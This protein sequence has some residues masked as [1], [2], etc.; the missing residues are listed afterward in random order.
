MIKSV[1]DYVHPNKSTLGILRE[2][3]VPMV[4]TMLQ[5]P[6][7]ILLP[8][9]KS[10]PYLCAKSMPRL[11]ACICYLQ[12][13]P[14]W[15]CY[16]LIFFMNLIFVGLGPRRYWLYVQ[17]MCQNACALRGLSTT[18]LFVMVYKRNCCYTRSVLKPREQYIGYTTLTCRQIQATPKSF[19]DQIGLHVVAGNVHLSVSRIVTGTAKLIAFSYNMYFCDTS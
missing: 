12:V 7:P 2:P 3:C 18:V 5:Q 19:H 15:F 14:V 4:S 16:K 13:A 9:Q 11:C 17:W 10:V 1:T 6:H 8:M